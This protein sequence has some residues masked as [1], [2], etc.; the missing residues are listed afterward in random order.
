M[1]TEKVQ[2]EY[3]RNCRKQQEVRETL[4]GNAVLLRC[5]TCA[6]WIRCLKCM[7][8]RSV[9]HECEGVAA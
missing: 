7:A 9:N 6:F 1:T 5:T 4:C 2:K 8:I 3:C